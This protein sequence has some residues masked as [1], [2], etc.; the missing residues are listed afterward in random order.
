MKTR[1]FLIIVLLLSI[2]FSTKVFAQAFND[3]RIFNDSTLN[4]I[5]LQLKLNKSEIKEDLCVEKR[6]SQNDQTSIWVIPKFTKGEKGQ[7]DEDYFMLDAY[8]LIV[9]N[10]SGKIISRFFESEDWVSEG[11]SVL[12]G[13][14][15]DT[16]PYKLDFQNRGFGIRVYHQGASRANPSNDVYFS[17]FLQDGNSIKKILDEQLIE[18]YTGEWDT[19]C[20]GKFEIT[21]STIIIGDKISKGFYNILIKQTVREVK[22]LLISDDCVEKELKA[23]IKSIILKYNGKE[24]K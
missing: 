10:V 6:I 19:N 24:Y 15:I 14:E 23:N 16:A 7:F 8:I 3:S 18:R 9:E 2:G 12:S 21:D 1:S 17:L 22:N 5:L 20:V 13:I 11:V 4:K